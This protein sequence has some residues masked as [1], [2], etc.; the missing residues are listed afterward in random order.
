MA[1]TPKIATGCLN[2]EEVRQILSEIFDD[3]IAEKITNGKPNL[4]LLRRHLIRKKIIE[5]VFVTLG[6]QTNFKLE[7]VYDSLI[8][9]CDE[10]GVKL[11]LDFE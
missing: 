8:S 6:L 11:E 5:K 3:V 9:V 7:E 1:S 2:Q 10:L 4:I